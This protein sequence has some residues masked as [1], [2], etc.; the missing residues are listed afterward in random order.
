[1]RKNILLT[2]LLSLHL[3]TYG[4][5]QF[6]TLEPSPN[7]LVIEQCCQ[8]GILL[9]RQEYQLEDTVTLK[10]YSWNKQPEFGSTLSFCV[11][12]ADGYMASDQAMR[13]WE[14]DSKY[15]KYRNTVYRPVLSKTYC[16]SILDKEYRLIGC[17]N[18]NKRT[19]LANDKW[20]QVCDSLFAERGFIVDPLESEKDGWL[21]W[22]TADSAGKIESEPL[23]LISYRHKLAGE[24]EKSIYEIPT[25]TTQRH[26]IGGVYVRPQY[27]EIGRVEFALVGIVARTD[28]GWQLI[29][30]VHGCQSESKDSHEGKDEHISGALTPTEQEN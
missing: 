30:T 2:F 13:P 6:P 15:D 29:R 20:A 22:L 23:T 10:R 4:Q 27:H 1:M 5:I 14:Y 25:P 16:K 18:P 8:K 26:V 11:V 19:S 24:T 28:N 3:S 21:I 17:M 7:Q 12:T 9:L